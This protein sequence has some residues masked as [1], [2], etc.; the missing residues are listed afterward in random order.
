MRLLYTRVNILKQSFKHCTE[1]VKILLFKSFFSALYCASLWCYFKKACLQKIEVAYNNS[2]RIFMG[3]PKLCSIRTEF[4]TR[5]LNHFD[6]LMR[7]QIYSLK[8]RIS[9]S[10][11]LYIEIIHNS[12]LYLRSDLFQLWEQSLFHGNN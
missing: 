12:D 8:R 6:A 10:N 11:N 5:N 9:E 3:L 7:K 4:V 2:L 1:T